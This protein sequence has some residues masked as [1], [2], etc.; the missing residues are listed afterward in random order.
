[1][2]PPCDEGS[3][4]GHAQ[5]D[6]SA[7]EDLFEVKDELKDA[8]SQL[9]RLRGIVGEQSGPRP[10]DLS[11]RVTAGR[12]VPDA[13]N[14]SI[15]TTDDQSVRAGIRHSQILH[16]EVPQAELFKSSTHL[17]SLTHGTGSHQ[18]EFA[19][20]ESLPSHLTQKI[21]QES[22]KGREAGSSK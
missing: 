19:R 9:R 21:L 13:F 12:S 16:A 7:P 11:G 8:M 22:K 4:S 17:R 5:R 14:Q 18:L 1:M 6:D 2:V 20:Y 15:L 10:P 3:D